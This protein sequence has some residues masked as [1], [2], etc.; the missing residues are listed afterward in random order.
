MSLRGFQR[1]RRLNIPMA[2]LFLR[3]KCP[4]NKNPADTE[5]FFWRNFLLGNSLKHF[6]NRFQTREKMR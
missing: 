4:E 2:K 6:E 5:K 1:I 3:M